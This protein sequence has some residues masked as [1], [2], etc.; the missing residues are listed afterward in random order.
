MSFPSQLVE[1][2]LDPKQMSGAIS[3]LHISAIAVVLLLLLLFLCS[4]VPHWKSLL[5]WS[6]ALRSPRSL[7]PATPVA[8]SIHA[9]SSAAKNF[10]NL[11]DR[12]DLPCLLHQ[13]LPTSP[14]G[15]ACS[16]LSPFSPGCQ[17][18]HTYQ[19]N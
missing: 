17:Y 16:A 13:L 15:C 14:V 8:G 18:A 4:V 9:V 10:G 2:L 1:I 5:I 12:N 11:A 19:P 6:S 7:H 3:S